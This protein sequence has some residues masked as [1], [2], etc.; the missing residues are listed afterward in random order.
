M[1]IYLLLAVT[2]VSALAI[3]ALALLAGAVLI[4]R[5]GL[6]FSEPSQVRALPE[7]SAR[8]VD[9]PPSRPVNAF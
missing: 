2:F 7:R 3:F 4:G 8:S 5:M 9:V 1:S 6:L